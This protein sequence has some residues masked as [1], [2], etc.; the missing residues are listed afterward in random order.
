M[1]PIVSITNFTLSIPAINYFAGIEASENMSLSKLFTVY[2]GMQVDVFMFA[3][4]EYG[5]GDGVNASIRTEG[6]FIFP[7]CAIYWLLTDAPPLSITAC[8]NYS[9]LYNAIINLDNSIL[10]FYSN[11]LIKYAWRKQIFHTLAEIA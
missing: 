1:V 5:S 7:H 10:F 2:S 3:S 9:H 4:N 11:N 6:T 8:G